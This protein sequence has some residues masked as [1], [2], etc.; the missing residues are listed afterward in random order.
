[1]KQNQ[2]DIAVFLLTVQK[3]ISYFGGVLNKQAK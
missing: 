2:T 3:L 1:M